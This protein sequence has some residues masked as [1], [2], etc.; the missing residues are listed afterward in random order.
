MMNLRN[1]KAK[2]GKIIKKRYD[3]ITISVRNRFI[4][5]AYKTNLRSNGE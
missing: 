2:N 4:L 3:N 5:D 1:R